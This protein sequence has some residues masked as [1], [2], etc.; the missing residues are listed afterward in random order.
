MFITMAWSEE[1]DHYVHNLKRYTFIPGS[2]LLYFLAAGGNKSPTLV[3]LD[4]VA[5]LKP[6]NHQPSPVETANKTSP[7]N[8]E[9]CAF[10]PCN[11]KMTNTKSVPGKG[12]SCYGYFWSWDLAPFGTSLQEE[13]RKVWRCQSRKCNLS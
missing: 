9:C 4:A 6:A 12:G 1:A 8:C 10:C 7:L 5:A 13:F 11:E 2:T 3:L